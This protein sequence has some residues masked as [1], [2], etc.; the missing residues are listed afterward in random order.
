MNTTI[1]VIR[2]NSKK[3]EEAKLDLY[4]TLWDTKG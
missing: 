4:G 3:A 1:W 2:Q